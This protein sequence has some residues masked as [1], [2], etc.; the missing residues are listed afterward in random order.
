MK[1]RDGRKIALARETVTRLDA[2]EVRGGYQ[3]NELTI[4]MACP[5]TWR[6]SFFSEGCSDS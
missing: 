5:D 1:K 6:C 4:C 3:T 2:R